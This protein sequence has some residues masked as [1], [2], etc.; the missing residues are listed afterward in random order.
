[1]A[2]HCLCVI[3]RAIFSFPLKIDLNNLKGKESENESE[4]VLLTTWIGV[5][6]HDIDE[7]IQ[8]ML[9]GILW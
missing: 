5:V 4:Q 9:L 1:L 7:V 2:V 6:T 8:P 3:D